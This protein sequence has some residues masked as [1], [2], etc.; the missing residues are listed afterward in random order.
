MRDHFI[1]GYVV[2]FDWKPGEKLEVEADANFERLWHSC[3]KSIVVTSATAESLVPLRERDAG[4]DGTI[5]NGRV[6]THTGCRNRLPKFPPTLDELRRIEHL[7]QFEGS[8]IDSRINDLFFVHHTKLPEQI[9]VRLDDLGREEH[10]CSRSCKFWMSNNHSTDCQGCIATVSG[11][12][13]QEPD[14]ET[15]SKIRF[16][17]RSDS[18]NVARSVHNSEATPLDSFS[19]HSRA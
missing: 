13:I 1:N 10:Y 5:Y 2:R 19:S 7:A 9:E 3:E 12:N 18:N 4:D 6:D 8:S 17:H 15:F 11:I 16:R 14:T